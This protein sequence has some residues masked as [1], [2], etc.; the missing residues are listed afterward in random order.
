MLITSKKGHASTQ[1]NKTG[2]HLERNKLI[3]TSSEASLPIL[4]KIELNVVKNELYA[5]S[6]EHLNCLPLTEKT[7]KYRQ[8]STRSNLNP[9]TDV[10]CSHLALNLGPNLMQTDLFII[11]DRSTFIISVSQIF[12]SVCNRPTD[13]IAVDV[14]LGTRP[15]YSLGCALAAGRKVLP[16]RKSAFVFI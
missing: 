14:E 7:P 13:N 6:K 11:I 12:T 16:R 9:L 15:I 1:F 4:L 10:I 2:I 8:L 3:T 5:I